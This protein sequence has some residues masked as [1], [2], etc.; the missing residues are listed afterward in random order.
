MNISKTEFA[1]APRQEKT[2][3]DT[4]QTVVDRGLSFLIFFP[5]I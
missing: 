4:A 1:T 2:A 3:V 5:E